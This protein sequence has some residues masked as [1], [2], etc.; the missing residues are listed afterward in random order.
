MAEDP[1]DAALAGFQRWAETTTRK[2]SADP[3]VVVDEMEALLQLMRGYLEI[4]GPADLGE[5]DLKELLLQI[6]PRKMTVFDPEDTEDTIPAVRDFLAYLAERGEMPEGTRRALE[7]ELDQ[8]APRFTD[9]VMD[10]SN[11]GMASTLLH[12][13]AAEGVDVDDQAAVDR[14]ID[15]YNARLALSGGDEDDDEEFFDLKEAFGLP[16]QM[17]P[18]RL[19]EVPEL[20]AAARLAPLIAE[21][22]AL[23]GWLGAGRAVNEDAGLADGDV[24]EAAAALGLAVPRFEH[25]WELALE[26]EFVELDEDET[27]AVPGEIAQEWDEADDDDEV[28][29]L[30][31]TVFEA[32]VDATLDIAASL[33][34]DRAE[35]L[36]FFGHGAALEVMLFL[37]RPDGLPV[38]ETSEVIR[39]AATDELPPARADEAWQSWAAAHGDPA[40]LLLEQ[41]AELGAVQLA[42]TEDGA[43]A[44][45]TPLGLAAIRTQ[46]V[47]SGVEIPLLPPPEQMTAA[48]LIAMASGASEDE[49]SAELAAWLAHR[50]AEPAA[51]ELL[52]VAAES[53]PASRILAVGVAAE[54]G[55][56]AQPAWRDALGQLELRGYAKA[57][58]AG[59]A[60]GD[61]ALGTPSLEPADDDLAWIITDALA[62][63]GWDDLSDDA[64]HEPAALAERLGETIPAGRELEVFEMMARVPHPDAAN[65]LTVI[66]R[67]HPDKKIAKLAR[68]SAYKAA[69]RQAAQ[70]Q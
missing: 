30:W 12:E 17:P 20:A 41:M 64:E 3:D 8:I 22:R 23:A 26:T 32:V 37:A 25:L 45:L 11:W 27:R 15:G 36:D 13:M 61:P 14:W 54:L 1:F 66:G 39:S 16:D 55:A 6:Y 60:E 18:V 52:A 50:I 44:R 10:P 67:Q 57:I 35:D 42:E 70:R 46:L 51:R 43:L 38:A 4:G 29:D 59:L 7:R 53:D 24:A 65:V 63:E 21:L 62:A 31:E 69:S 19:P 33:D 56:S 5:G 28:L 2:L 34:P 47:E 58:L 40:R 68:K 48:Q 9:A 49:F